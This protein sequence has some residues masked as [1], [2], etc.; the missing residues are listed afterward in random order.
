MCVGGGAVKALVRFSAWVAAP[1]RW[2][3]NDCT[4]CRPTRDFVIGSIFYKAA[5]YYRKV[6]PL[7]YI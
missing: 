2:C 6:V 5:I 3:L 7:I 4:M 1:E